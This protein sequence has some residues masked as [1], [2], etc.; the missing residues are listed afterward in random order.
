[1]LID[2]QKFFE[3]SNF[4]ENSKEEFALS[5]TQLKSLGMYDGLKCLTGFRNWENLVKSTNVFK[6]IFLTSNIYP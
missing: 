5:P 3:I 2:A 6:Y 4:T 1:M